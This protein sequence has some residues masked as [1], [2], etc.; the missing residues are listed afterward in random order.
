MVPNTYPVR[1]LMII[2]S[3]I[4]KLQYQHYLFMI[5]REQE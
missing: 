2:M 5:S 4:M 3:I 1:N